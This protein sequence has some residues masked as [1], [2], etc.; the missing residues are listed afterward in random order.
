MPRGHL[1]KGNDSENGNVLT[2]A[3]FMILF[4]SIVY[5]MDDVSDRFNSGSLQMVDGAHRCY[6]GRFRF[7]A[8]V[9]AIRGGKGGDE[10]FDPGGFMIYVRDQRGGIH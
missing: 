10:L 1:I 4:V 8:E 6:I 5:H 3:Y 9:R 7:E 2:K